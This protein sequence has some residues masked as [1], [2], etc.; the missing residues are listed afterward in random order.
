MRIK[1]KFPHEE[2]LF[3]HE[4]TFFYQL[5]LYFLLMRKNNSLMR[6]KYYLSA[7]FI[8]FEALIHLNRPIISDVDRYQTG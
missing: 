5:Q 1:T 7:H 3:T 4:E 8:F 2:I 6:K